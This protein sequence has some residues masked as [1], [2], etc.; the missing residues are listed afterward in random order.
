[1]SLNTDIVGTIR[2]LR[3]KMDDEDVSVRA[4]ARSDMMGYHFSTLLDGFL[5]AVEALEKVATSN[6]ETTA[7]PLDNG[8]VRVLHVTE[9]S[10]E[11][12]IAQ[13]A[14][15]RIHSLPLSK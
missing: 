12:Q 1:M 7:S 4:H 6:T 10:W 11:N 14:L 13:H 2:A 9:A 3:E 15:S 8:M 5:I